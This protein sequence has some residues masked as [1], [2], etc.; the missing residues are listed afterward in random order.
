MLLHMGHKL[1]QQNAGFL[2]LS[3]Q[4]SGAE[5]I[6]RIQIF[7]FLSPKISGSGVRPGP[8]PFDLLVTAATRALIATLTQ[9]RSS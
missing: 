1:L 2:K 6:I 5:D 8:I 3:A 9:I 4:G 7:T